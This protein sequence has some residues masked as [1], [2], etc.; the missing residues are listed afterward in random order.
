MTKVIKFASLHELDFAKRILDLQA[1]RLERQILKH[2]SS[3]ADFADNLKAQQHARDLALI[4]YSVCDDIARLSK[5][6]LIEAIHALID[7]LDESIKI[8]KTWQNT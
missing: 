7:D 3:I 1:L 5:S 8:I 6:H 2:L 4:W